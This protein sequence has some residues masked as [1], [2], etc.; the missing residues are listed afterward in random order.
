MGG[1]KIYNGSKNTGLEQKGPSPQ[2]MVISIQLA[3]RFKQRHRTATQPLS[4]LYLRGIKC[5][6]IRFTHLFLCKNILIAICALFLDSKPFH[7]KRLSR[8]IMH[9]T[10]NAFCV[11]ANP[12][13]TIK[14]RVTR[15]WCTV[16]V[17]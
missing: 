16:K 5:F 12:S 14:V 11:I 13:L 17:W 15:V 4:S 7:I 9:V 8:Y 2:S 3:D 10:F 6:M 1:R